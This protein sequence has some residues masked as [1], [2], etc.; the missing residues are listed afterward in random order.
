MNLSIFIFL[1]FISVNNAHI[2]STCEEYNNLNSCIMNPLCQWCNSSNTT[3]NTSGIC[4]PNTNCFYNNSNCISNNDFN[5][6]CDVFYVFFIMSMLFVLICCNLYIS[7]NTKKILD[8]YFDDKQND[9]INER[10]KE[11]ALIITIINILLFV[12][13]LIFWI[14]GSIAF[15]YYFI[16]IISLVSFMYCSMITTNV[17]KKDYIR[18]N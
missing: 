10:Y 14:I 15:I 2:Y 11:K 13:P 18:I 16:C 9:A 4:H 1:S 8:K 5:Y 3:L 7:Y 6:V 12:P 17:S